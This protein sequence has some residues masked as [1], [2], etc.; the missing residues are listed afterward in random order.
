MRSPPPADRTGVTSEPPAGDEGQRQ[1]REANDEFESAFRYAAIGMSL[2]SLDGHWLKVNQSLCDLVGF[3]EEELLALSFQDITHPDDLQED[4]DYVEQ[5]IAGEIDAYQMEKRYIRKD[6]SVVPVLLSVSLVRDRDGAPARFVSQIQDRTSDV[7]RRA[8]ELELS[9]RRR[10]DALNVL[11]GGVAHDF[12]N[13]L[14]GILGHTS[15]ALGDLP[16][17]SSTR[18]HLQE[19]ESSA[20]QIAALTDQMLAFSGNAW[21]ELADIELGEFAREMCDELRAAHSEVTVQLSAAPNVPAV[22]VDPA[23]LRR[24][25][26]SLLDNAVEALD[27]TEGTVS[28]STGTVHLTR[29]ALD[30]YAVGA[31]AAPGPFAYVEVADDGCGMTDEVRSRM[32]EPFFTTKFQGRGLGLAA[33]DGLVR[34]HRGALAVQSVPGIG[35]KVRVLLPASA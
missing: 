8:L 13:L 12:N 3:S 5:L 31:E 2:V 16:E 35:T 34:G 1:L 9:E 30:S 20:R 22:R 21:R 15:L 29:S 17:G 18:H 6:G 10:A 19:V 32:L 23:Q 4:L 24:I 27:T 25:T 26:S 7:Q 28:I 33:V 11:A 14:V